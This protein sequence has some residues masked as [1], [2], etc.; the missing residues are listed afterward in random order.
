MTI[1]VIIPVYNER[2]TIR[3][4]LRRVRALDWPK[5]ILVVDDA[6][7]DGSA[8]ILAQEPGIRCLCH[9]RNLGKGMAI[10]TAL[11]VATGD[12]VVIQDADLEYDPQ[13]V[14]R[15]IALIARG[16][17]RAVYGSRF[18]NGR[19]PMRLANYICNRIL[20]ATAN[21]LYGAGITDE[22]TCYKAIDMQLLRDLDLRCRRFEFCPEVTAKLGRRGQRILEVPIRYV[23][24]SFDAGKKI[25]WWDGAQ[26]LWTL[27]RYRFSK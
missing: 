12:V 1:S 7:T 24:R 2:E 3:E 16:E 5:E 20:A 6:S 25:R 21:L 18:L 23:P 14:P 26:A 19:P 13:D 22:A 9:P 10:R 27:I 15:L 4:A 8:E 17:A 11:E